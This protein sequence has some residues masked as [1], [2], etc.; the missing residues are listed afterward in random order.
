MWQPN[1]VEDKGGNAAMQLAQL[2]SESPE[3]GPCH[4][5]SNGVSLMGIPGRANAL[6]VAATAFVSTGA[7]Y[8]SHLNVR[9]RAY[10][11]RVVIRR[12]II[13]V[14]GRAVFC[15]VRTARSVVHFAPTTR[16]H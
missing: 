15:M 5:A 14:L 13:Q 11:S 12:M 2:M 4:I 6:F 8:E 10:C 3:I 9:T 16:F 1:E 7:I